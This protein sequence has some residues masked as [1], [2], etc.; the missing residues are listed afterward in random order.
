MRFKMEIEYDGTDYAGWQLQKNSGTI[1]G[2]IEEALKQITGK[3]IRIHG[4]GR[5]DAGVHARGQVGHFDLDQIDLDKRPDDLYRLEAGINALT[6]KAIAIRNLQSTDEKFHARFSAKSRT[7]RY[8]ICQQNR[9]IG[10]RYYWKYFGDLD[11]KKIEAYCALLTENKDYQSFCKSAA[12]VE[13]YFCDV[14]SAAW[15]QEAYGLKIFELKANRFLHG[16]VRALV[17]TL[18]K[19]GSGV[20]DLDDVKT[21]LKAKDRGSAPMAAPARGLV[22][23]KVEY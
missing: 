2:E 11:E 12:D 18:I 1:Q 6:S 9:S 3:A 8:Y 22:L 20:L 23:E 10:E 21:I 14:Y 16:M 15:F 13:H 7:Y 17:G 5:T 19:V 4:A